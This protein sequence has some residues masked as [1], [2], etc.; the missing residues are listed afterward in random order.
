MKAKNKFKFITEFHHHHQN[1][2]R[3]FS[4]EILHYL[5]SDFIKENLNYL[6]FSE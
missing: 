5:F 4:K 1:H 3:S 2:Y 6:K